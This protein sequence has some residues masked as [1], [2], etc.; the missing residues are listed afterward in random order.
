MLPSH[1]GKFIGLACIVFM[2]A[3]CAASPW[4]Q[5]RTPTPV[6][7]PFPNLPALP[8]DRQADVIVADH[9]LGSELLDR[10]AN[11]SVSG[12]VLEL[13]SSINSVSWGIWRF[14]PGSVAELQ[15]MEILAEPQAGDELY[16]GLADYASGRWDFDGPL[17]GGKFYGLDSQ[18]HLS[19]L[20]NVH[21]IVLVSNGASAT[22]EQLIMQHDFHG[23]QQLTVPTALPV[24]YLSL[25]EIDGR[26]AI[27]AISHDQEHLGY[28]LSSTELGL[29]AEDWDTQIALANGSLL[30]GSP[31]MLQ[32]VNGNPAV[33]F[34]DSSGNHLS[35]LRSGS[36]DGALKADWSAQV[37]IANSN[38]YV[39]AYSMIDASGRPAIA[40]LDQADNKLKYVRSSTANGTGAADW[41]GIITVDG[42]AEQG[43]YVSAAVVDGKPMIAYADNVD[44]DLNLIFSDTADG[45]APGDWGGKLALEAA[46]DTG[47]LVD[48]QLVA[49]KPAI[50]YFQIGPELQLRYARSE[51]VDGRKAKDWS[52]TR[53]ESFVGNLVVPTLAVQGG[54]PRIAYCD[55]ASNQFEVALSQTASGDKTAS[56]DHHIL[57]QEG[58]GGAPL[59]PGFG[60]VNGQ[61]A[62]AWQDIADL[63]LRYAVYFP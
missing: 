19:S 30:G 34:L 61:L 35:Y 63:G 46:R 60:V 8:V 4:S 1:S 39:Q 53:I 11:A 17:P 57:Q 49:G 29:A 15:D 54:L 21:V 59:A 41:T 23:W 43:A 22:V 27:A 14:S 5:S 7:P 16:I 18:R 20:G 24:D 51:T 32:L 2:L 31:Y 45:G 58:S 12:D 25:R 44:H 40:F 13:Q 28:F 48:L 47:Y 9:L 38:S 10:S 37:D 6:S 33:L 52:F 62:V 26:P 3:G 56:W 42:T 36:P 50:A 55:P